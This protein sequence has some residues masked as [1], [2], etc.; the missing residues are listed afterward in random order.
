MTTKQYRKTERLAVLMEN[1]SWHH[2]QERVDRYEW[3]DI[4]DEYRTDRDYGFN[5]D[6]RKRFAR[7]INNVII[8]YNGSDEAL[9]KAI[10]EMEEIVAMEGITDDN[11]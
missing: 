5:T 6:G 7:L 11:Q 8:M 1:Y 10:K 2:N 3:Q 4:L 9:D